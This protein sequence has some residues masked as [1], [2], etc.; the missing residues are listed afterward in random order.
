MGQRQFGSG[1]STLLNILGPLDKPP[2]DSYKLSGIEISNYYNS[3][4]AAC[5][6]KIVKI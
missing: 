1:K 3:E 4:L 5:A 6:T 2:E